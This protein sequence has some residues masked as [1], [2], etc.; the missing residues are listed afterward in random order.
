[1]IAPTVEDRLELRPLE[2]AGRTYSIPV[3]ASEG[4]DVEMGAWASENRTVL[5]DK[6]AQD[7]AALLRGFRHEGSESIARVVRAFD[8]ETLDYRYGVSP[9]QKLSK[10][11]YT[12]TELD[13]ALNLPQHSELSFSTTF[14]RVVAFLCVT[15][16]GSG[17][18]TPI[19]DNR[20]VLASLFERVRR[21]FEEGIVY[22]RNYPA[23]PNKVASWK[24][25]FETEDPEEVA[26]FC[27]GLGITYRWVEDGWLHTKQTM[28][29]VRTLPT[30]ED[31]WFNQAHLFHSST[32]GR[33]A[34]LSTLD[35]R[36][37]KR[38]PRNALYADESRIPTF[39]IRSI[40]RAFDR[41]TAM[42]DWQ[43][44]DL[45]VLDNLRFSHGRRPFQGDRKV[46][47]AMS[48]PPK[49]AGIR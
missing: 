21:R 14:P 34:D 23:D 30:G 47:V 24:R 22:V 3:F 37:L 28:A 2:R 49:K 9:R 5:E 7:G 26:S 41:N 25:V 6:L 11:V 29:A 17:G 19:A 8:E 12:S 44:G 40:R 20:H 4:D 16:P 39:V 18:Q 38:L 42:F 15:S 46:L 33:R 36:R 32:V 43:P 45:I 35:P 1:M 13:P 27:E 31:V 10:D 48:G